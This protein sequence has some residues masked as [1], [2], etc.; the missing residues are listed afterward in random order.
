M[1]NDR[2][3]ADVIIHQFR[4]AANSGCTKQKNTTDITDRADSAAT[5]ANH[6]SDA[7]GSTRLIVAMDLFGTFVTFLRFE[8]EGRGRTGFEATKTDGLAGIIAIAI[9]ALIDPANGRINLRDQFTLTIT[10]AQL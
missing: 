6:S 1:R 5:R 4:T 10:G 2:E 9:G 8:A 7:I 3:K